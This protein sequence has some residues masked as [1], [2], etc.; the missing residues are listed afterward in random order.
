M[1]TVNFSLV[2]GAS[3][4]K[5]AKVLNIDKHLGEHVLDILRGVIPNAL[6]FLDNQEI[7]AQNQGK[8]VFEE[9]WNQARYFEEVLKGEKVSRERLSSIGREGKNAAIQGINAQMVKLAMVTIFNYIRHNNLKSK[10]VL[11]VHDELVVEFP[12][13]EI[14]HC[15]V[16]RQVMIDCSNYFLDGV[17]MEVEFNIG[18]AWEK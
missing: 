3:A 8:I 11:S 7:K 9:K 16:Y 14:D 13:E 5:V 10:I 12:V 18:N 17:E 2:Y 15:E 1:K 4:S 6:S